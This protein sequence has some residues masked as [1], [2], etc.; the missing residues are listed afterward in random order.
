MP[1]DGQKA[2][3]GGH[4]DLIRNKDVE[5]FLKRCSYLKE[6]SD[7]EG[8]EVAQTFQEAPK[9]GGLPKMVVACDASPY[10]DPISRK[11]PSTQ[12]GYVKASMVAFQMDKFGGL[13]DKNELVDPFKVAEL[14]RE[15]N[16]VSFTLPGSNV[17]Y[18]DA[19][20]VKN[21]FRRAV[22]DQ[23]SDDRTRFSKGAPNVREMLFAIEGGTITV[24]K[25]PSC[26]DDSNPFSF[27]QAV[28]ALQCPS[29]DEQVYATDILRIHETI[30]DFGDNAQSMTRFM[31]AIE[32]LLTATLIK[33][34]AD[35]NLSAL[36]EWAF[37]VDGPLAI[38]GQPAKIHAPLM[39]FYYRL[40]E[41][42]IK[43]GYQ[44][45]LIIGLQKEGQVMEH[46]RSIKRFIGNGRYR[47]V[48]DAYR[49]RFI[50]GGIPLKRNFGDDTYYGQD[51]IFKTMSGQI[52]TVALPY[53]FQDKRGG[54]F[55]SRKADESLYQGQLARAFD[56][57]QHL[58]F[59]LYESAVIP[60]ALAHRHASISLVPGGA[61]LDLLTK[62]HL[63][64]G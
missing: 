52:F 40:S 57:I 43:A 37:I 56:L 1:Y 18:E 14:H 61:M 7:E 63:G 10:S 60:V 31:N 53:P 55:A 51:F 12:V 20:T 62:T 3:K 21:G 23:L 17:R 26:G 15:A 36:S 44:P 32:H 50:N 34:L 54:D 33:A 13:L 4:S 11:F 6:P 25:C 9:G 24:T 45:P 27:Q 16:S 42:M 49:E 19:S 41:R 64:K 38:F 22:H 8:D 39:A 58:E 2:S 30:S 47:V 29:C 59:D 48:D 28:G 5:D 46:A 35:S